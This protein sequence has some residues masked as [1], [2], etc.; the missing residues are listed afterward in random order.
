MKGLTERE[1]LLVELVHLLAYGDKL[2]FGLSLEETLQFLE[3]PL[4]RY[5]GRNCV[6]L[7]SDEL[8]Q[9]IK[10]HLEDRKR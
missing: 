10:D 8:L 5:K 4:V 3:K 7:L 2:E 1:K 9:E 6:E